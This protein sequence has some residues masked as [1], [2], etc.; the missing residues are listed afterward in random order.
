[1]PKKWKILQNVL[2]TLP[3]DSTKKLPKSGFSTF[4]GTTNTLTNDQTDSVTEKGDSRI[5]Q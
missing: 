3:M 2:S 4:G 5:V 1:M